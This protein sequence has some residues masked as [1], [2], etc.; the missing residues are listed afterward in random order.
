MCKIT[1]GSIQHNYYRNIS[2]TLRKH[3]WNIT[4]IKQLPLAQSNTASVKKSSF[5]IHSNIP[6]CREQQAIFHR[7][8]K[9][10]SMG[11]QAI[12]LDCITAR[13]KNFVC[14]PNK[15]GIPTQLFIITQEYQIRCKNI[16]H[17]RLNRAQLNIL[18]ILYI[19]RTSNPRRHREPCP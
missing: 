11:D 15:H 10:T 5:N 13:I 8:W 2:E 17:S 14:T 6:Y 7:P 19:E 3:Y 16:Q 1:Y 9:S 4:Q 18:S 12:K